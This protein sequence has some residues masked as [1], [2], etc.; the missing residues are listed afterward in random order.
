MHSPGMEQDANV[1][2]E[3]GMWPDSGLMDPNFYCN[4]YAPAHT[5]QQE[6]ACDYTYY[7]LGVDLNGEA[8]LGEAGYT[9][10]IDIYRKSWN[11]YAADDI[12]PVPEAV[13]FDEGE[14][15]APTQPLNRS[16]SM[17]AGRPNEVYTDPPHQFPTGTPLDVDMVDADTLPT[18]EDSF[19]RNDAVPVGAVTH[20]QT[21]A[22]VQLARKSRNMFATVNLDGYFADYF[23]TQDLLRQPLSVESDLT[24]DLLVKD[25]INELGLAFRL[26]ELHQHWRKWVAPKQIGRCL[27]EV[28]LLD[29]LDEQCISVAW[30][31][32]SNWLF[33]YQAYNEDIVDRYKG[34]PKTEWI[35]MHRRKAEEISMTK[36]LLD[37]LE[38]ENQKVI[39][40]KHN[41]LTNLFVELAGQ[42][43][44]SVVKKAFDKQL[45]AMK[46]QV[47][48]D[49]YR[50]NVLIALE[51]DKRSGVYT[52]SM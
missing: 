37:I 23:P 3:Q 12:P 17:V 1:G 47:A 52:Y 24:G 6:S 28:K 36:S 44:T 41:I 43:D 51:H 21:E 18:L 15:I 50:N 46:K 26:P 29:R 8:D 34:V 5:M 35:S 14:G 33:A 49:C 31:P 40:D 9:E 25:L 20:S 39:E 27:L 42:N 11:A 16:Y 48:E 2:I 19:D 38:N 45:R 22:P 7:D 4:L 13:V 32:L 10:D 30:L